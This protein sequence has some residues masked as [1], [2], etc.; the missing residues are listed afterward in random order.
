MWGISSRAA[1]LLGELG[2]EVLSR[3]SFMRSSYDIST[4]VPFSR[5]ITYGGNFCSSGVMESCSKGSLGGYTAVLSIGDT[6]MRIFLM[7]P[8]VG[9]LLW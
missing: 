5:R 3:L 9:V 7:V 1:A 6:G 8:R 4:V 2:G